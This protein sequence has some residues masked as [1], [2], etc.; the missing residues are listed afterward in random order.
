MMTRNIAQTLVFPF[1]ERWPASGLIGVA[2]VADCPV[3]WIM[4]GRMG[5]MRKLYTASN[6]IVGGPANATASKRD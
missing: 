4:R 1:G 5:K 2:S 3:C 6:A